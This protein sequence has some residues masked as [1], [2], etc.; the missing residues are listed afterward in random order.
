MHVVPQPALLRP[1]LCPPRDMFCAQ[2]MGNLR[3]YVG[4]GH[5]QPLSGSSEAGGG[6]SHGG[7]RIVAI[8]DGRSLHLQLQ[9][10][11]PVERPPSRSFLG[12]RVLPQRERVAQVPFYTSPPELVPRGGGGP[13]WPHKMR[14]IR[15]S[16][17]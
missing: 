10:A 7:G 2:A 11:Q 13:P 14:Q 8:G 1:G 16:R 6:T 4:L 5:A 9:L 3:L 12:Q 17:S 15:P